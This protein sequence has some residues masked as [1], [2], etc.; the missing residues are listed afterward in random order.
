MDV[1]VSGVSYMTEKRKRQ[2]GLTFWR[3]EYQR[4]LHL[5]DV[6]MALR[7]GS[8][9]TFM[10][11]GVGHKKLLECIALRQTEGFMAGSIHYNNSARHSGA[12]RDIV[13]VSDTGGS[14]FDS[15]TVFDYLFFAAKLRI[16][17]GNIECRER[18]R[19]ATKL[20]NLDG[21][22]KIQT[23]NNTDLRLLTIAGELVGMPT[24]LCILN[25]LEGLDAAGAIDVMHALYKV[26]K[27]A[28]TPTTVVYCVD[29]LNSDMLRYVDNVCIFNA[30]KLVQSVRV[31]AVPD[32]IKNQVENLVTDISLQVIE[33]NEEANAHT[34]RLQMATA[35]E[36]MALTEEDEDFVDEELNDQINKLCLDLNDLLLSARTQAGSQ[37]TIVISNV[38]S[39]NSPQILNTRGLNNAQ[40][41][42]MSL[43]D[44]HDDADD[45]YLALGRPN[46]VNFPERTLTTDTEGWSSLA[47]SASPMGKWQKIGD[48][49][50]HDDEEY[51][52]KMGGRTV[53]E[54]QGEHRKNGSGS[55]IPPSEGRT[56]FKSN[57]K[58]RGDLGV[59]L[60][61]M[62]PIWNEIIILILRSFKY[63]WKNVSLLQSLY[64]L[65]LLWHSLK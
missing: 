55:N 43:Y 49:E 2:W 18:A 15:L 39:D 40:N 37:G 44:A 33:Y 24:L 59:P 52:G 38:S 51:E 7:P 35:F 11:S 63:H 25:P 28:S 62:K 3:S 27:R 17:Q 34:V 14:H 22:S 42:V 61:P 4:T 20:V 21:S 48:E 32:S 31:Q 57:A 19:V 5:R 12:F 23:L 29:G 54:Q 65:C 1:K 53:S 8:V 13:F 46:S 45:T 58:R 10:G 6:N 60:R 16:S 26:S 41:P 56:H 9:S 47:V 36:K 30:C 50:D 64:C